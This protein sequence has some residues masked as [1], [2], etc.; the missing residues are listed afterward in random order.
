[1]LINYV[2][3]EWWDR[4]FLYEWVEPTKEVAFCKE[5]DHDSWFIEFLETADIRFVKAQI[6]FIIDQYKPDDNI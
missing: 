1:M 4:C 6:D 3:Y 5:I 2:E